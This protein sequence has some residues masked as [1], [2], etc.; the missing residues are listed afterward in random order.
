MTPSMTIPGLE[1]TTARDGRT[2]RPAPARAP[3][4]RGEDASLFHRL[5]GEREAGSTAVS[6]AG[7][8]PSATE[9][10]GHAHTVGGGSTL[11]ELLVGAWEDLTAHRTTSCPACGAAMTPRYGAGAEALGGRCTACRTTLS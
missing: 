3:R 5:L 4:A 8:A 2:R 6:R 10:Q 9:P 1:A 7:I 11:D